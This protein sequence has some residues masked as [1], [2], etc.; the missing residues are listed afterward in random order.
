MRNYRKTMAFLTMIGIGT[1]SGLA[2]DAAEVDCSTALPMSE[3]INAATA[4]NP[5]AVTTESLGAT[6]NE[7]EQC[8][9]LSAPPPLVM[10]SPTVI[11]PRSGEPHC[12]ST[13]PFFPCSDNPAQSCG[14][15]GR[16]LPRCG[17]I[18]LPDHYSGAMAHEMIH[19]LLYT[20]RHG[21]WA[22]H[23]GPEFTCQ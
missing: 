19:Y 7:T 13:V 17:A 15:I 20:N 3:I 23:T 11:C 5:D 21:D 2:A 8:T 16:F 4:A 1:F 9:A 6:W 12:L 14:A 10:L 18:E 22:G